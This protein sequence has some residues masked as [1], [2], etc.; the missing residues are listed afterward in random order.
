ML[1]EGMSPESDGQAVNGSSTRRAARTS[2][3]TL[4]E[5]IIVVAIIGLLIA[6][7]ILSLQQ[8]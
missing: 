5:I 6:M 4:V 2:A 3:F 1:P 8:A 7:A